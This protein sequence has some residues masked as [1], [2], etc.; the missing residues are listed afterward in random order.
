MT[1]IKKIFYLTGEE[2][3]LLVEA[4]WF[5]FFSRVFLC[6]PFRICIRRLKPATNYT[7]PVSIE[8]LKKIKT[9]I[10]RANK[11]AFWSNICLVKSIAARFML[12][13]RGIGSVLYL[14]LRFEEGKKLSAHAW[15][16][17]EGIYITPILTS[18]Y[19][20]VYKI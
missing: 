15:L 2:K 5:L 19:K 12:Q 13:R 3:I 20:E 1:W 8:K 7:N 18:T 17:S 4:V 16:M 6:L 9:A 10:S 11:L 14:G